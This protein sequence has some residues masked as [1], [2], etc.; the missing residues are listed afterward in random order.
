LLA[1]ALSAAGT[2]AE[3]TQGRGQGV[4]PARALEMAAFMPL[5]FVLRAYVLLA[6][7]AGSRGLEKSAMCLFGT[8]FLFQLLELATLNALPLGW[9]VAV[10]V[11]FALG[12]LI[13]IG[14]LAGS[15]AADHPAPA[16]PGKAATGP[17]P[18]AEPAEAGARKAGILGG[19]AVAFL[20][21]LKLLG[22]GVIGKIL[23]F[24]F[25]RRALRNINVDVGLL[26][27]GALLLAAVAF[28]TWFAVAKIRL[29][30]TLGRVAALLGWLELLGLTAALTL[31][32][33][34]LVPFVALVQQPVVNEKALE[35][36][37]ESWQPAFAA[38]DV[39]LDVGWA[40]L[41]ALLFASV[42][43]RYDPA[44]APPDEAPAADAAS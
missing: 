38:L 40:L 36:L 23:L 43:I 41:T 12:V 26:L 37:T 42:R 10:W 13:L 33:S 34:F 31:L 32:V 29:R 30:A 16:A 8:L 6:R 44:G 39:T 1:G 27:A 2:V 3:L 11:V 28:L 35:R 9:R 18:A 25:A 17:N 15:F 4:G 19:I 21:I 20:A 14:A 5:M 24:N 7:E 22:K